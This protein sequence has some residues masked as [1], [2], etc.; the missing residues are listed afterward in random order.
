MF[1]KFSQMLNCD[2]KI[3][4]F[5]MHI[6]KSL[7]KNALSQAINPNKLFSECEVAVLNNDIITESK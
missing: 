7:F 1:Y 2:F 5:K 4:F 3:R 6:S